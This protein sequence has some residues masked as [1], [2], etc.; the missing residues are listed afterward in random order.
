MS[1]N[2]CAG[3]LS[4]I[5]YT[6]HND[7]R[8]D[9]MKTKIAVVI[10][11][12]CVA[13]VFM[14]IISNAAVSPYFM[15]VN[16]TLLPFNED[17]MPYISGGEILV[18]HWI[19]DD[20]LG[21]WSVAAEELERVRV[22]R[23]DR[24]VDLYTKNGV[25]E[26]Q[27]GEILAWPAARRVGGRFYVPL[28]HL[29]E[30]FGLTY[31]IYMVSREIIPEEQMRVIRIRPEG[32]SGLDEIN[33]FGIYKNALSTAYYG[34]YASLPSPQITSPPSSSSSSPS[35]PPESPSE[36]PDETPPPPVVEI[37]PSFSDVTIHHSFYGISTGGTDVILELLDANAA[38]DYRFC[39]FVSA[40]D[41]RKDA[42]L[43][44]RISGSGHA[45]GIWLS[46][47]T[48]SEYLE[49]SALLFEAAKIKTV[50]VSTD[51]EEDPAFTADGDQEIIFWGTSQSLVYDDT[52]SVD[53]VTAMI[54]R[55]SGV[56]QNLISSCS[57]NTALM[58]SGILS[59]LRE[60]EY[61]IMGITETVA[62]V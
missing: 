30:F 15:A 51:R 62:P 5:K 53:E 7:E 6:D 55:E 38:S 19:F 12:I 23:G 14:P 1:M 24:Y 50:L 39:F 20:S 33:F 28:R 18:P 46:E 4:V 37:P 43:I 45:I 21:V 13:A 11:V 57:E 2:S 32:Y 56:R 8:R 29:C 17:T 52:L 40:D 34:Y 42:G 35:P 48:Y 25:A 49:T 10:V 26:N 60:F 47:G 61:S 54:S 3:A 44:R 31:D 58:L 9:G 59:Y 41:I 27:D 22:Y 16:D 36:S